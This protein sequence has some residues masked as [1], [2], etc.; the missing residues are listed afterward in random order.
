MPSNSG[1]ERHSFQLKAV[2]PFR[3][4]LAVWTLRRRP[5]N[6]IDRWDG[7]TYR[8]VLPLA[9][10]PLEIAVTQFGSAAHP[11]LR[12]AI[13]GESLTGSL[14][15]A[16]TIALE[17]LLG[18]NTDITP[19]YR[20]ASRDPKLRPLAHRFRGMKPPR[21]NTVFECLLNAIACQQ[22]S[23]TVGILLL[24]R[25]AER[26]GLPAIN[27]RSAHAF[28]R[29]DDL[30]AINPHEIQALGFSRRKAEYIINL[31][32]GETEG[33]FDASQLAPMSNDEAIARL[34]DL[35]G[36]GRWSAEYALL[37]GLGRWDVFPG[38]DVGAANKMVHW[39]G[40]RK[41]LDSAGVHRRLARW[42][43]YAG[44]VYF[45]LLLY[46]LADSGHLIAEL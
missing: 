33:T 39:L 22:V 8:R 14:Q 9:G 2:P 15:R 43:P 37:R 13:E 44:L 23:L 1:R 35:R 42:Q 25:L 26:F 3:L 41:P 19:F 4:E 27:N 29:P 20:L 10:S 16:A 36:I 38:D 21:F 31:A 17:K 11:R 24:N 12:V 6:A 40:L 7:Q 5:E 34:M 18:L 45:H 46:G 28:P 30:V 32:R